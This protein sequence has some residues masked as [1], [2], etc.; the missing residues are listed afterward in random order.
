MPAILPLIYELAAMVGIGS[1]AY[2]GAKTLSNEVDESN[3]GVYDYLIQIKWI[4]LILLAYK[5]I[6]LIREIK[7]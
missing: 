7:E 4:A 5:L 1:A 3:K 6:N 2:F